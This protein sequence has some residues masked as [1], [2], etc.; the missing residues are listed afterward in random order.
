MK[1]R[2]WREIDTYPRYRRAREELSP[3]FVSRD[4]TGVV[5]PPEE[6]LKN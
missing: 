6:G 4:Y 2:A 3:N 1:K 5:P